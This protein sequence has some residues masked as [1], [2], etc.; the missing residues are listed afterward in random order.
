MNKILPL[1]A[2]L[3]AA[4]ST[5][6]AEIT[7]TDSPDPDS[8]FDAYYR[9]RLAFNPLEATAAGEREFNDT[10]TNYV[11]DEY[12]ARLL[13]FY[14]RFGNA[15]DKVDTAGLADT[16][17]LYVRVLRWEIDIKKEGLTNEINIVTSPLFGMPTM[18]ILPINQILS[19]HLYVAQIAGGGSVHPFGDPSDYRA[20]LSRLE[21]YDAFLV[22]AMDKMRE[23][24]DRGIV[25]PEILTRRMIGQLEGFISTPVGEHVFYLPVTHIPDGFSEVDKDDIRA[26]YRSFIED[27]LIPRFTELQ[28]FLKNEYLPAGSEV[29]GIG[30]RPHGRETY[31]YLIRFHTTTR[32]TADE[33]FELG[34]REVARIS[35]EM[36]KVKEDLGFRGDLKA[37][38]NHVRTNPDLMSYEEP[39]DVIAHFEAI[40]ARMEPYIDSLFDMKPETGFEIRRTESFRESSASAEYQAGSLDG[41]RPGVFYVPIPEVRAYNDFSDESLFLH[42]AIPGHH[43]QISLQQENDNLPQFMHTEGLG[44]Y[45]EGWALYAESLGGQL[46]LYEDPYQY[47]GMLSAEMHRAIRLVVDVG[48]HAK[49]W[50]REQAIQYSLDHEAESEASITAEIERYM[51]VP[52]QALSYKIGQLKILELRE[53][54]RQALGGEFD[55]REFHNQVLNT[56]SLPLVLLE[57][58]IDR[59]IKMNQSDE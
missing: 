46:G 52:G 7:R 37:F 36:E 39:A 20:W 21:D 11:S 59:W 18:D 27:R 51:A 25:Y 14:T 57:D 45:V 55:I 29:A 32:M 34:Q 2:I 31:D 42:E 1:F 5:P 53:R 50:S 58:K 19:F 44:V 38:F 30:S 43:Y 8:L 33:I 3:L 47:F 49:G 48:M 41:E 35:A 28:D 15:L 16:K 13:D 22:T 9:E 6:P 56:G 26:K 4:C 10:L 24:M 54:A 40:H 23:G 12:Q 17:K